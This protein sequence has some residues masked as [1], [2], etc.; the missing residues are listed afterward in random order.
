[1][2]YINSNDSKAKWCPNFVSGA[3]QC[4]VSQSLHHFYEGG[5]L[6]CL[7]LFFLLGKQAHIKP[8]L[9]KK[10][11]IHIL[12]LCLPPAAPHVCGTQ[13]GKRVPQGGGISSVPQTALNQ[14]HITKPPCR[15]PGP[16]YSCWDKFIHGCMGSCL[17]EA[18]YLHFLLTLCTP[19]GA[20]Q[21]SAGGRG[22]NSCCCSCG[23]RRG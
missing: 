13:K 17:I 1:M 9:Y 5:D 4:Y 11:G 21:A 23:R 19:R 15:A 10:D 6:F 22:W 2:S 12:S 20:A 7:C 16:G 3:N 18:H 14:L 8:G